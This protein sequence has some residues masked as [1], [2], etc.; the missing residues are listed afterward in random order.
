MRCSNSY[1]CTFSGFRGP[2]TDK[3]SPFCCDNTASGEGAAVQL[4]GSCQVC[5]SHVRDALAALPRESRGLFL[6]K[7]TPWLASQRAELS[8][9][10]WPSGCIST[11]SQHLGFHEQES[12]NIPP[13]RNNNNAHPFHTTF[14]L[15]PNKDADLRLLTDPPPGIVSLLL[16]YGARKSRSWVKQDQ[17]II[18]LTSVSSPVRSLSA[19]SGFSHSENVCHRVGGNR[20][21]P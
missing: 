12:N 15:F 21:G 10:P 9:V 19:L 4:T 16:G 11:V 2:P 13:P 18:L 3:N 14:T 17:H 5:K 6:F 8:T 20:E 7:S 1:L